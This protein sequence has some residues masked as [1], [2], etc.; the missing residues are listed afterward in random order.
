MKVKLGTAVRINV[1]GGG[2][3]RCVVSRISEELG[4]VFLTTMSSRGIPT[5]C[6]VAVGGWVAADNFHMEGSPN[7]QQCNILPIKLDYSKGL[8][9]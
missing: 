4:K 9:N 3:I 6:G 5:S 8:V 1:V 7:V 2:F